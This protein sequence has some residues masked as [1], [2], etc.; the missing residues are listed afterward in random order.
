MGK[1]RQTIALDRRLGAR[2]RARRRAIGMSQERLADLTGVT[3][4]QIQKYEKGANRIAA[5]RLFDI[6]AALDLPIAAF[7]EDE[8]KRGSKTKQERSSLDDALTVGGSIELVTR[9]AALKSDN[10][11]RR[12]LA[13]IRAMSAEG[14]S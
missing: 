3:F 9:Y 1:E 4:Q 12:V 8:E 2:V 7:F 5:S 6:S 11:R 14:A 13:L 10:L